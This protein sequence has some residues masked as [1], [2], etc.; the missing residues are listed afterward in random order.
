MPTRP[1]WNAPGARRR[2]G[3]AEEAA[4]ARL[5]ADDA[6]ERVAALSTFRKK[7][8]KYCSAYTFMSQ[9]LDYG[10]PDLEV[11]YSFAKLL[12]HRIAGTS[13]ED[14]DVRGLVL[15]DFR[16]AAQKL[17]DGVV[18]G[19]LAPMGAGGSGSAPRRDTMAKIVEKLNR[20]W[21]DEGDPLV[22]ARAVNAVSDVVAA[23]AVTNT[24]ITN[25]NN[26]KEAV[27]ADGRLRNIVIRALMSMMSNEL[28]DL[29]EQALDDPQAI[30]PLAEQVYDLIAQ[31]KRYDIAEL[32]SYLTR[33]E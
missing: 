29:A 30:E 10:D 27:L 5:R 7:L 9:A 18:G 12:G 15:K 4:K 23:D 17:P 26:T 3:D 22:K 13:L 1:G 6:A 19:E 16:I 14:V 8:S 2:G 31:G 20:T 11:F 32:A 33:S 25:T 28:G 24:Q 21:G